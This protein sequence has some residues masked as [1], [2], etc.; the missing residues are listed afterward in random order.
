[1]ADTTQNP[2]SAVNAT[3][4]ALGRLSRAERVEL[5]QRLATSRPGPTIEQTR[6]AAWQVRAAALAVQERAMTAV[7]EQF[8]DAAFGTPACDVQEA[9][10][11]AVADALDEAR[12]ELLEA[13]APDMAA[14]ARKLDVFLARQAGLIA[15]DDEALL[16]GLADDL[17]RLMA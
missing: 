12:V 9:V 13:E 8:R 11:A 17:T 7:E 1:M 16:R 10:N 5:G 4:E 6:R 2:D 3:L 15:A 14:V